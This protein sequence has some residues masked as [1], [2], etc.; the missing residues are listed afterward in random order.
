MTSAISKAMATSTIDSEVSSF[1]DPVV[2][3]NIFGVCNTNYNLFSVFAKT[4]GG[5]GAE[6]R[7]R[8]LALSQPA[9]I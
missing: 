3:H 5:T 7:H 4:R 1:V 6:K 8:V 9:R 2:F